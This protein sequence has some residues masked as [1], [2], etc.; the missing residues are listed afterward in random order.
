MVQEFVQAVKDSTKH[1]INQI[2][3][4]I[5]GYVTEVDVEKLTVSVQPY[6]KYVFPNG[7]KTDYPIIAQIPIAMLSRQPEDVG[8]AIPVNVGDEGLLLISELELDAWFNQSD[9]EG[10]LKFDLSNALFLPGI[11][12]QSDMLKEAYT[13][14]AIVIK[15]KN[16]KIVVNSQNTTIYGD[17]IVRGNIVHL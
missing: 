9:S 6:G 7:Q 5:P 8:I 14:D 13:N 3:T 16:A 1:M 11:I 2:H 17:L 12:R 10:S 4:I 15:N